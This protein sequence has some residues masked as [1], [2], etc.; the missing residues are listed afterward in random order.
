MTFIAKIIALGLTLNVASKLFPTFWGGFYTCVGFI[1][2][3]TVWK[4]YKEVL[5]EEENN[6]DTE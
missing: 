3:Q 2:I 4:L 1:V 6:V 5:K